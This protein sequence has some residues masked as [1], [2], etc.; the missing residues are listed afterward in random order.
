MAAAG[1]AAIAAGPEKAPKGPQF[2]ANSVR[3][4]KLYVVVDGRMQTR[5][6]RP[7]KELERY[8]FKT[9]GYV[10]GIAVIGDSALSVHAAGRRLE[11]VSPNADGKCSFGY[12]GDIRPAQFA[13]NPAAA[14]ARPLS[15]KD[16]GRQAVVYSCFP[17]VP[18]DTV[19]HENAFDIA[20]RHG[21]NTRRLEIR[22]RGSQHLDAPPM[23]TKSDCQRQYRYIGAKPPAAKSNAPGF[24]RR[25]EAVAS[26]IDAVEAAFG[27]RLVSAVNILGFDAI[28]NA[29]TCAGRDE[30]WFYIKA[31]EDEPLDE[32]T[33]IAEHEALHLLV[34]RLRLTRKREVRDLFAELKGFGVFSKARFQLITE[35]VVGSADRMRK[36]EKGF[37]FEF[38]SERH[39]LDG[40][41]GGHPRADPDEFSTSFLHTLM[42]INRMAENLDQ[43]LAGAGENGPARLDA[44]QRHYIID[45]YLTLLPVVGAAFES[46]YKAAACGFSS[47]CATRFIENRLLKIRAVEK[48]LQ[49]GR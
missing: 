9:K 42:Y 2:Q 33:V 31:F 37:F 46:E 17:P 5:A 35:G 11:A 40:M 18:G 19:T 24:Q 43:P 6:L 49:A 21:N 48:Q 41:K 15:A 36:G 7:G 8:H 14:E 30:I 27:V 23:Y 12:Y 25:L 34:D 39:F 38:I 45:T 26:G 16:G 1:S 44:G 3:T 13:A 4:V 32:L 29:V 20:W 28:H 22:H 47:A 10:S